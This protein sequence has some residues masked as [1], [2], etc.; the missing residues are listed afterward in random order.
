MEQDY[1]L[2]P[3]YPSVRSGTFTEAS[4]FLCAEHPGNE[5]RALVYNDMVS[6][7]KLAPAGTKG[8][9]ACLFGVFDGHG[10]NGASKFV[11]NHLHHLIGRSA[12][13]E[14]IDYPADEALASA[15][16][17]GV[18]SVEQAYIDWS[19]KS[20]DT[21]GCCACV[22]AIRGSVLCAAN[23][24]DCQAILITD[25][26][27]V[28]SLSRPH[29]ATDED[30]K[31]R[32]RS[33]GG[34]VLQGRVMG[35]LEPSRVIGDHDIKR[36][37]PGCVIAEPFVFVQSLP[38]TKGQAPSVLVVASDGVWDFM[39]QSSVSELVSGGIRKQKD[40]RQVSRELVTAAREA[41]S[42][43]DITVVVAKLG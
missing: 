16:E 27:S 24:G 38:Y 29:R 43:D 12:F 22:V 17:E 7:L 21:S 1:P 18:A 9:L 33:K 3:G 40:P 28:V 13:Y 11:S 37:W 35:V 31:A 30:E 23:V 34:K 25:K 36:A 2:P 10:G 42:G 15:V 6:V 8:P 39:T 14:S 26:G 32:I 5:D 20:H 4:P 19:K 41:G